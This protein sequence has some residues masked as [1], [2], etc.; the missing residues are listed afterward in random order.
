M[1]SISTGRNGLH[2][3]SSCPLLLAR[4]SAVLA[5]AAVPITT[6]GLNFAIAF[7]LV[8]ALCSP[9]G[10]RALP[11]LVMS[12]AVVAAVALFT[13]LGV[14]LLYT[15]AGAS[16]GVNILLKYRKVLLLPVLFLVFQ[17]G[18]C[19]K[20]GRAAMWALVATLTVA[21]VLTYTNFFGWTAVGPMYDTQGPVSKSWVFKD[22]ISGGLMMAFLVYLSMALGDAS[23]KFVWRWLLRLNAMLALVNVLFVL[24]GRTGQIVALVYVL[25]YIARWLMMLK[26]EHVDRLR[27]GLT[28]AVAVLTAT[29]TYHAFVNEPSRLIDT[30]RELASFKQNNSVTSSGVRLEFYRR[31]IE[32][33]A[34]RPLV[35]YGVG[36]VLPEFERFAQNQ[37]GGNAVVSSNPHN[38]FLLMGVQLGSI[39]I[40]LFLWLLI[41]IYREC[42]SID[43]LSR[44][45]V[46]GYL[47]AF[48][49]GCLANSL[50]LNFTEGNLF[51]LLSGILIYSG[52]VEDTAKSN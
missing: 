43:P 9:E 21:M 20:W 27:V 13:A 36:S 11:K 17:G 19:S 52:R 14:S 6:A 29:L 51:V 49:V 46:Y 25:M 44:T 15:P 50:L 38:E 33:L 37:T 22:H 35:G 10:W 3:E 12:P 31:S 39:G 2:R 48:C 24:Q 5:I 26:R 32:L 7:T 1:V 23:G 45:V 18:D 34:R 30:G 42:R 28:L 16:E 41:A 8:F 4:C 47:V 40:A